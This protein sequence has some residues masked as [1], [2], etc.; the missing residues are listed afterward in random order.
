M[1]PRGQVGVCVGGSPGKLQM[2]NLRQRSPDSLSTKT[3]N[4][5]SVHCRGVPEPWCTHTPAGAQGRSGRGRAPVRGALCG[6]MDHLAHRR[7]SDGQG[8][9]EAR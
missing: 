5:L 9:D 3:V 8:G 1:A 6:E 2:L 4:H 7:V